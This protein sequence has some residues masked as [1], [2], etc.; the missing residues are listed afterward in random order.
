M[1]RFITAF[2]ESRHPGAAQSAGLATYRSYGSGNGFG[3]GGT[4]NGVIDPGYG[5]ARLYGRPYRSAYNPYGYGGYDPCG[6]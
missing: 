5:G 3:I 1:R 6:F 2:A 4:Y